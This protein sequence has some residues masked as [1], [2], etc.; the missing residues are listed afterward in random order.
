MDTDHS[1]TITFIEFWQG[2]KSQAQAL[3][4]QALHEEMNQQLVLGVEKSYA[5]DDEEEDS[6]SMDTPTSKYGSSLYP[7]TPLTH[8]MQ[9]K[10]ARKKSRRSKILGTDK[11]GHQRIPSLMSNRSWNQQDKK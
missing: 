9:Q 4:Q 10:M 7:S 3:K 5:I 8:D 1:Q 6:F 11:R 2:F